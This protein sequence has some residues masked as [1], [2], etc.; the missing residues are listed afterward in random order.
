MLP[1]MGNML[2]IYSSDSARDKLFEKGP[3]GDEVRKYGMFPPKPLVDEQKWQ[4]IKDF[5]LKNAPEKL[6]EVPRKNIAVGDLPFEVIEAKTRLSPPSATFVRF[7][8]DGSFY[9]GDANSQ[10]LLHFNKNQQLLQAGKTREGAVWINESE[11]NLWI[12]VMG[13]FSPTDAPKGFIMTLPKD[14]KGGPQLPIQNLK[15]PVHTV[16]E[17]FNQDGKTDVVVCEFGKWT[18]GLSMFLQEA[19]G[20]K[21]VVLDSRPGATKAYARDW[22]KDGL[23]DVVA[24][25]AQGDEGIDVYINQGNGSFKKQKLISF[26]PSNGSSFFNLYDYD[27]D[28]REDIFYTAGDNADFNPVLKPYHGV[29]VF[30]HEEDGKFRQSFFYQLNGAYAVIPNDYDND[31]DLDMAAISFFPDYQNQPEESFVY[32]QN[33]GDWNFSAHTFENPTRGR[34]MVM[35]AGDYDRDGDT[36]LILGS[37]AFEVIP[38]M[39]LVQKW[40]ESGL[41]YVILKNTTK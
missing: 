8:D 34:W 20:F 24:L 26:P 29:Y 22:N 1:R 27:G 41:P 23:M 11:K 9:V 4:A 15:R 12:T 35:D 2:G 37:L 19:T 16:M 21:K 5:Y 25:F 38:E 7:S 18:G 31:G 10:S 13:S 17:D 14:G 32:L 3:G 36:D 28:G 6:P 33:N 39:G 30:H 40:M